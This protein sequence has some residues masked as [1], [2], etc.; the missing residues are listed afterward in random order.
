[1][2]AKEKTVAHYNFAAGAAFFAAIAGAG[3]EKLGQMSLEIYSKGQEQFPKNLILKFN[4]AR[5][6]WTFNSKSEAS[7]LFGR[8]ARSNEGLEFDPKDGVLSHRIRDLSAMF[9][10]GDYF[11]AALNEPRRAQSIIQSCALT[12]LG[13][14]AF[15]TNQGNGAANFLRKAIELFSEN[16][17][18]YKWLTEVLDYLSADPTEVLHAFYKA[19]ELYPPNLCELLSYGVEAELSIGNQLKASTLLNNWVLYH[20]RVREPS[21]NILSFNK[22]SLETLIDNQFLLENWISDKF[23]ELKKEMVK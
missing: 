3:N 20:L 19:V 9:C 21:G 23:Q 2:T 6:L 5:A 22:R 13:V 11:H 7:L 12:Y 8:L 16:F 1:M 4:A 18:A 14:Y 15:E 10:Y 17:A